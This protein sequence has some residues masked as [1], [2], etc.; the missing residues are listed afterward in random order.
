MIVVTVIGVLFA[1]MGLGCTIACGVDM[2]FEHVR[3]S[4]RVR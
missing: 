3:R 2:Y 1:V 4:G